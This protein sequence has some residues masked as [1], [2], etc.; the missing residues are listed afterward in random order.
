MTQRR[1]KWAQPE[2]CIAEAG[3][4]QLCC[5][6]VDPGSYNF[7]LFALALSL[8]PV[9]SHFRITRKASFW[10]VI[11]GAGFNGT[12]NSE[13]VVNETLLWC[14]YFCYGLQLESACLSP[15][16]LVI[17]NDVS[18]TWSSSH[19]AVQPKKAAYPYVQGR[20]WQYTCTSLTQCI[21]NINKQ[22]ETSVIHS[23][24]LAICP[25]RS[26][27]LFGSH[28]VFCLNAPNRDKFH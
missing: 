12:Y 6:M 26:F 8:S 4:G 9:R 20:L 7:A 27:A 13:K 18:W 15:T 23:S 11:S 19:F 21:K 10:Q 28:Q 16:Y 5:W 1:C 22:K 24:T 2:C 25:A 14:T 3:P 17:P